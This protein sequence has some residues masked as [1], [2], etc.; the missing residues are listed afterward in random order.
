MRARARYALGPTGEW[1]EG[2]GDLWRDA[3][4][5]T[6]PSARYVALCRRLGAGAER[7]ER[8]PGLAGVGARRAG[9]GRDARALGARRRRVRAA[10][11]PRSATRR[12][13]VVRGD[14]LAA[15]ADARR[16]RRGARRRVVA[17]VDPPF[18]QK[19]DWI[20]IPDA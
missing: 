1:T 10:R 11:A 14:G 7:P 17:L 3:T 16:E 18:T 13:R 5:A 12:A 2:I 20:A 8:Y 6:T 9:A 4:A 19:A 15:L